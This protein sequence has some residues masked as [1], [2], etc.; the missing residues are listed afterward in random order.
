VVLGG[1]WSKKRVALAIIFLSWMAIALLSIAYLSVAREEA[2]GKLTYEKALAME[3]EE[4]LALLQEKKAHA[5]EVPFS[6]YLLGAVA[7]VGFLVGAIS[8][9]ALQEERERRKAVLLL[10]L[11]HGDE[12]KVMEVLL[13]KGEAPQAQIRMETGLSKVRL[14]RVLRRMEEKGLVKVVKGGRM[15]FVKLGEGVERVLEELGLGNS[16]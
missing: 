13:K 5:E 11:F 12:A 2:R 16:G 3:K 6:A 4:I 15:N 14:T 8:L 10:P 7:V 9:W 1:K